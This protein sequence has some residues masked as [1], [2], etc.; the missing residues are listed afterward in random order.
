M[1]ADPRLARLLEHPVI[2]RG[3][4]TA[5]TSVISSGFAALDAALPGNGWP[6]VGLVE[7]LSASSGCGELNLLLPALACLTQSTVAR[8]CAWISPPA[9]PGKHPRSS[10]Q[11]EPFAPALVAH[12]LAL[13]RML[14][15][16][17]AEPLWACEQA[18]GSGACDVVLAWIREV[19][20]R[21]MRRLQLATERG[22][23]L[24]FV[25]RTLTARTARESSGAALRLAVEPHAE[26]T[27]VRLVKSRGG[28]RG[29]VELTHTGPP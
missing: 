21:A 15:V 24:A 29:S 27:R 6:R 17:A 4:S 12:G 11:L 26:G 16:R 19:R 2:W 1:S 3:R 28:L 22:R 5:R 8:W 20:P 9:Y 18:L 7:I 10:C 14:I 23:T 13:P 25:L